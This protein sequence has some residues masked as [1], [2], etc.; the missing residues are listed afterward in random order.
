M[1]YKHVPDS[2]MFAAFVE[3]RAAGKYGLDEI[4][5]N[6]FQR[7]WKQALIWVNMNAVEEA[8]KVPHDD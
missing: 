1:K 4:R 3:G 5:F 8:E 7:G 6:E 2:A